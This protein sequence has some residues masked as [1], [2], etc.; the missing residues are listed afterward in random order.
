M[1]ELLWH[2]NIRMQNQCDIAHRSQRAAVESLVNAVS[3][4]YCTA[5]EE[6]IQRRGDVLTLQP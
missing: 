1:Y 6:G 3:T 5:E 4:R 2:I